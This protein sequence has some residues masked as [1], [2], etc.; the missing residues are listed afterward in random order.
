VIGIA[1]GALG[2]PWIFKAVRTGQSAARPPRAVFKAALKHAELAY[3]LK[4]DSG[5]IEMR[6]HLCWYVQSLPGAKKMR[7]ELVKINKIA[8]IRKIMKV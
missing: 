8:D 4:G 3:S 5:I 1:R 7:L 6:K 2:R